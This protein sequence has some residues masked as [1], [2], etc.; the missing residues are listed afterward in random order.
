MR[1][2]IRDGPV[3]TASRVVRIGRNVTSQGSHEK[4]G[5]NMTASFIRGFRRTLPALFAPALLILIAGT[6]WAESDKGLMEEIVVTAQKRAQNIQ[7]VPI[8]V[9]VVTGDELE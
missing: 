3:Y 6:A 1:W 9:S 7:E 4:E 8:A 5:Y 2:G